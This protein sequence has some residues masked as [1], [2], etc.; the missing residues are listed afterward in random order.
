VLALDP[1]TLRRI[2][3]CANNGCEAW[4]VIG[5]HFRGSDKLRINNLKSEL[6]SLDCTTDDDVDELILSVQ[7]LCIHLRAAGEHVTDDDEV[8]YILRA[9]P[10][11]HETFVA[12]TALIPQNNRTRDQFVQQLHAFNKNRLFLAERQQRGTGSALFTR[13][14]AFTRNTKSS[15]KQANDRKCNNCGKAGH[16]KQDCWSKGGDKEGQRPQNYQHNQKGKRNGRSRSRRSEEHASTAIQMAFVARQEK[17][18]FH[19]TWVVDSG[20]TS[21]MCND[22]N[23]F[24]SLQPHKESI[25]T[26]DDQILYVEEKGTARIQLE[27]NK[28][29]IHSFLLY[30][31]LYIPSL[32]RNLFSVKKVTQK[33]HHVHFVPD[34]ARIV[35]HTKQTFPLKEDGLLSV[36]GCAFLST[37][38]NSNISNNTLWHRRMGHASINMLKTLPEAADGI[39][40]TNDEMPLCEVCALTKATRAPVPKR[41]ETRATKP[42]QLVHSDIWGP[43]QTAS[44]RGHRYA[45]TFVDDFSR[46]VKLYTMNKKSEALDCLKEFNTQVGAVGTLQSDNGTE[47]KSNRFHAY[48][49][50]KGIKQQFSTPHTPE[51]NG[52]AERMWRTLSDMTRALLR[53]AQLPNQFWDFAIST[54]A[55]IRNR[56]L[57]TANKQRVTPYELMTGQRPDL[58]SFKVFGSKAY[59][60]IEQH[61][62]N[63]KL[64]DRAFCGI[65]LGYSS[66]SKGYIIYNQQTQRTLVTRNVKF[67]E[68]REDKGKEPDTS[69]VDSDGTDDS[70][71]NDL[72]AESEDELDFQD[73]ENELQELIL[74][75][76]NKLQDGCRK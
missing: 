19:G 75:S 25:R 59:T 61:K 24:E 44:T 65:F 34:Q 16:S 4:L 52:V 13:K 7:D 56:S 5:E 31:V 45:I 68:S 15:A 47:F 3:H 18:P 63:N 33:R 17:E 26:A 41:S 70:D 49:I 51:Q 2:A 73:A 30:D 46:S 66:D 28:G 14:P 9:L 40:M 76:E 43:T 10:P 53:D 55:Y 23:S 57:T 48:C 74:D 27:D 42:L 54:A 35:T 29:E 8:D 38:N 60:F 58:S 37:N 21:H 22:L 12:M 39:S 1:T 69:T 62:R 71:R 50:D 64:S 11:T 20:C 67:D 36:L 72:E 32:A 6:L